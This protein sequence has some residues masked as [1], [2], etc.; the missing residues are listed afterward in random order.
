[1]DHLAASCPR[2]WT[3]CQDYRPP[4]GCTP[5][6]DR[7]LSRNTLNTCRVEMKE[8]IASNWQLPSWVL[9][10]WEVSAWTFRY[11]SQT[12]KPLPED[13]F[14]TPGLGHWLSSLRRSVTGMFWSEESH[15]HLPGKL[16]DEQSAPVG[17]ME[18]LQGLI[19]EPGVQKDHHFRLVYLK[20]F[21]TRAFAT[22]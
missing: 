9:S 10:S 18:P 11:G 1:M 14:W 21:D 2:V 7:T 6:K 5:H 17:T 15:S 22:G 16:V 13:G 20:Y 8:K 19:D 12:V 4:K 3:P